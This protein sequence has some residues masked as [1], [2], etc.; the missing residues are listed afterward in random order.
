MLSLVNLVGL[1]NI[2]KVINLTLEYIN[3]YYT[4]NIK[5]YKNSTYNIKKISRRV[6]LTNSYI[7]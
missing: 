6:T 1:L 3:Y 4:V 7:P 5:L 2:F